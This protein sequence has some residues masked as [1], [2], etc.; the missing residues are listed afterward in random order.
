MMI[1]KLIDNVFIEHLQWQASLG[2][3]ACEMSDAGK[4]IIG[5]IGRI[6]TILK[7]SGKCVYVWREYA[8]V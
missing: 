5:C 3:P 4:I 7:V 1:Q 2:H 8:I 6:S